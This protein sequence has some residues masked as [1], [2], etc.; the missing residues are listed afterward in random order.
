MLSELMVNSTAYRVHPSQAVCL[1]IEAQSKG[2]ELPVSP[3][4]AGLTWDRDTPLERDVD[5]WRG[6]EDSD[7]TLLQRVEGLHR[8][9]V[10]WDRE[11]TN[12]IQ[13]CSGKAP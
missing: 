7:L 3:Q 5:G 8:E 12:V 2:T 11:Q 1:E 9:A 13:G 10:L 6:L 4:H